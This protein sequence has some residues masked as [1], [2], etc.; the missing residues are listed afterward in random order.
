MYSHN[1]RAYKLAVCVQ[2]LDSRVNKN[3]LTMH[4]APIFCLPGGLKGVMQMLPYL[5]KRTLLSLPLLQTSGG[6]TIT[7]SSFNRLD[8]EPSSAEKTRLH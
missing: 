8:V 7:L 5:F 4:T 6:D 1:R 3:K 2:D